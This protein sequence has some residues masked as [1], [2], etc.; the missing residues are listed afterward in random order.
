MRPFFLAAALALGACGAQAGAGDAG[1]DFTGG[2]TV[3]GPLAFTPGM[4]RANLSQ[5]DGGADFT[6]VGVQ[7]SNVTLCPSTGTT[8]DLIT[9]SAF[10]FNPDR[11]PVSAGTYSVS[12]Q[13]TWLDGGSMYVGPAQVSLDRFSRGTNVRMEATSGTVVFTAISAERVAGRLDVELAIPD[14]GTVPMA[15]TFDAPYCWAPG[16]APGP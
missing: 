15:A 4:P 14:G 16:P 8:G 12:N 5:R 9:L 3:A 1:V 6:T 10:A 2:A 13:P 7:I 11:S